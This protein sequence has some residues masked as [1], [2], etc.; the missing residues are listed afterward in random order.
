MIIF[1]ANDPVELQ[2]FKQITN[3]ATNFI[4]EIVSD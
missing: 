1:I 2:P 3:I 4:P